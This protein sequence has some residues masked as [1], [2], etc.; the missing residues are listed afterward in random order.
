MLDFSVLDILP[1]LRSAAR[2]GELVKE[3]Q[4][5]EGLSSNWAPPIKLLLAFS[6]NS[7]RLLPRKADVFLLERWQM[8]RSWAV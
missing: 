4:L 2:L 7:R 6:A 3:V 5:K 8:T 1:F